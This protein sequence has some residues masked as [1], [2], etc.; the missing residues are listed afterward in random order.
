M[1]YLNVDNCRFAFDLYDADN[2]PSDVEEWLDGRKD[3]LSGMNF[4]IRRTPT[5]YV[6]TLCTGGDSEIDI[7]RTPENDAIM[8]Q[9]GKDFGEELL[10]IRAH[11]RETL[12]NLTGGR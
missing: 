11:E 5:H 3:K 9:F 6:V 7:V 2:R 4:S 1:I 12:R 10:K 8:V